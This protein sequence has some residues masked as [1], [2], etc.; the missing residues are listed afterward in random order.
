MRT[1]ITCLSITVK[2][3]ST[4]TVT[5]DPVS[6]VAG[7]GAGAGTGSGFGA[8]TYSTLMLISCPLS[9]SAGNHVSPP[10][11]LHIAPIS[12]LKWHYHG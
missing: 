4:L 6:V 5:P 10:L 1:N 8:V 3:V 9:V 7:A 12:S 11:S 2:S